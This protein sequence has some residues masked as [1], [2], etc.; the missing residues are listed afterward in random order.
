MCF[1][2]SNCLCSLNLFDYVIFNKCYLVQATFSS[3]VF[4]TVTLGVYYDVCRRNC[5][6]IISSCRV[7]G[8][9]AMPYAVERLNFLTK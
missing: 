1:I 8:M 5:C 2:C 9:N 4:S 7:N 3:V 6:G